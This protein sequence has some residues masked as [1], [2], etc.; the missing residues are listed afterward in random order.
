MPYNKTASLKEPGEVY[1]LGLIR[2]L[3][4]AGQDWAIT[5]GLSALRA[6]PGLDRPVCFSDFILQPWITAIAVS[7]C[8]NHEALV[9]AL[10]VQ[11]PFKVI[12]RAHAS[13]DMS[14]PKTVR[15]RE[16]LRRLIAEAEVAG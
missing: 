6:V 3:V 2:R 14:V 5:A 7:A 10:E 8:R 16:A 9:R 1:C 11:N 4:D 15:A 13:L 12:E